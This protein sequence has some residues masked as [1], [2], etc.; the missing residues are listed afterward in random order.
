MIRILITAW[1][2]LLL[3]GMQQ[4]LVVHEVDHLRAKVQRGH[5]TNVEKPSPGECLECELLA[6]GS[7]AVPIADVARSRDGRAPTQVAAIIALG[8]A[9]AKPAFYQSR[10]PPAVL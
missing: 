10:G 9:Q 3:V 4:Q 2:S 6:G 7:N 5:D 8:Q 1:L